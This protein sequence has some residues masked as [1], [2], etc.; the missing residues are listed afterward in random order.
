MR[1]KQK[2]RQKVYVGLS[3]GVDSSVS[4]ALLQKAGYDVTGV[5]I[6][7]WSPDWMECTWRFDRRDAMRV[8]ARLGIPF[9]TLDL[10]EE[11]KRQ[12]VDYMLWEYKAGR[13][14]NPDVMCNKHVKFGAFYDWAMKQGADYVATGHY[15]QIKDG[16]LLAGDDDNKDQSYFLWTIRTEQ[17]PHIFFPVGNIE[18]PA[19]RKLA[20]KFK[21]PT[22][23]KKDSQGLCFI[24]KVDMK[25]FL[26]HYIDE[27][28]GK[29]LNEKGNVIGTHNG[30]IFYT[31][32]ERHGFTI[33]EKTP[34]DT[35]YYVVAK[36]IKKNTITVAQKN[37]SKQNPGAVKTV[38][39][40][41]TNWIADAPQPAK[42]YSARI[43]YRQDL[44]VCT[45]TQG[46][47]KTTV[48]FQRSQE[49][50]SSG[51][52]LVLYNKNECLGG[53]VIESTIE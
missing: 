45:V 53:G 38:V 9:I 49:G 27:K 20:A 13:T 12:V 50:V 26:G 19:V 36:N 15:A 8:C 44:Q 35:P 30:A 2:Q 32:G 33:T 11:Y 1:E 48:T 37:K 43:R 7:V 24:G 42:K 47:K 3:G 39:L 28:P 25:E 14:P 22:A 17:L 52:S 51:Q 10:E 5:F 29:A 31:I 18:K 41:N 4:A 46:K 40:E 6:K 16:K 23:T 21:L 34:S